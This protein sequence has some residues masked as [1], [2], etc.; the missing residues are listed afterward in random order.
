LKLALLARFTI[1]YLEL[2]TAIE[3]NTN[4]ENRV[5]S[6]YRAA[7]TRIRFILSYLLC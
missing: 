1:N 6:L 4:Q 7:L 5:I 2:L 3:E